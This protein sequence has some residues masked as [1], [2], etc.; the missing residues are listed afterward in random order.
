M[1]SSKTRCFTCKKS[2]HQKHH[3]SIEFTL[4]NDKRSFIKKPGHF[5]KFK[6]SGQTEFLTQK[7]GTCL[8]KTGRM[9][10]LELYNILIL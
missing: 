9:A 6:K 1:A 4:N 8:G 7:K 10:I 5:A 3:E 2:K